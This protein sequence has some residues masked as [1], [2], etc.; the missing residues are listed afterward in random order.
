MSILRLSISILLL[1]G[2][3]FSGPV[4][5]GR[6]GSTP[7]ED[8]L[9]TQSR[10]WRQHEGMVTAR[11][12]LADA[13]IKEDSDDGMFERRVWTTN[14]D[15]SRILPD[16]AAHCTKAQRARTGIFIVLGYRQ[17]SGRSQRL[18]RHVAK[19]MASQGWRATLIDVAE[20]STPSQ[21]VKLIDQAMRQELPHIDRALLV[22]FSKGGWD[23]INWFH[24]PAK[25]HPP[26][27]RAKIRL[28]V[29]FAAILRGSAVAGWGASH[30][31]VEATLFR[32]VMFAR[33][34]VKGA[35]P[36]YLRSL[37]TDPW[38][39][40]PVTPLRALAPNMQTIQFVALPEGRDGQTHVNAFFNW[41]SH[42]AVRA[43]PWL[44]PNDG[45]SESAGQIL[46]PSEDISK[47]IVRVK[48]SHALLD[49]EYLNGGIVSRRYRAG[50]HTL[51]NGGDEI[52][53]D[54][55]RALPRST[56]GW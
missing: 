41:T 19:S 5:A 43:E 3:V 11:D 44:G 38:S 17:R 21:D 27:Q 50:G 37:S 26:A 32:S 55:M 6:G 13:L 2:L 53:D 10:L 56:I 22:G 48:S 1:L 24:G 4:W 51:W 28:L 54:L 40:L 49:G 47:W 46:P 39:G 33:F 14:G 25:E 45:M 29:D 16:S 8:D 7:I 35:G 18:V 12:K 20:W 52:M 15:K 34:G 23:W 36:K 30:P 31:G 42:A 9:L